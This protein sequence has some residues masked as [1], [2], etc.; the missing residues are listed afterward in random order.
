MLSCF[1][2]PGLAVPHKLQV[3]TLAP[4]RE[5][6]LSFPAATLIPLCF[7][8]A[9]KEEPQTQKGEQLSVVLSQM[10]ELSRSREDSPAT[11]R[12]KWTLAAL[13]GHLNILKH[14]MT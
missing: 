3:A 7:K 4:S 13:T 8:V 5:L 12:I 2:G 1:L 10:E 9:A 6:S 11:A 14:G